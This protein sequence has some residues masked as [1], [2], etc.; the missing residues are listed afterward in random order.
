MCSFPFSRSNAMRA[1]IAGYTY[2]QPTVPRS[3]LTLEELALLEHT[4]L[5]SKEDQ[6]SLQQAGE[7]LEDQIEAILDLWYGFVG[8]QPQLVRAF[9]D[10]S[11]QPLTDYLQRVRARFGQW[12]RDTC[13]R[14]HDQAWLDYQYEIGLRHHRTKKNATDNAPA[15]DGIV[16]LRYLIALIAPIVLTIRE[17]L[18]KKG[19]APHEVD[20]MHQAWLKAVVL[21]V[22]LWSL[23]YAQEGDY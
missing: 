6:R 11:G 7:V 9:L 1:T 17:F 8:S 12:I 10:A 19:H 3:P 5:W 14:P 23:P 21:Q 20:R 16:P 22:A 13:R 15:A 2:G 18:A 4:V